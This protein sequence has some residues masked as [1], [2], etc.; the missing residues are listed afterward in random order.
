MLKM[1]TDIFRFHNCIER[2]LN[3]TQRTFARFVVQ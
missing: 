2:N 3:E 1:Q